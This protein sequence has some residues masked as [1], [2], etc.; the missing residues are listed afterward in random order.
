M[1]IS[2]LSMIFHLKFDPQV[3]GQNCLETVVLGQNWLISRTK[4]TV[5][6]HYYINQKFCQKTSV[7]DYEPVSHE[8]LS[9]AQL[10]IYHHQE[11]TMVHTQ[12]GYHS[13]PPC[14]VLQSDGPRGFR[15]FSPEPL[16]GFISN[17]HHWS[18]VFLN[19]RNDLHRFL[20]IISWNAWWICFKFD[21]RLHFG[22]PNY[23]L[24]FKG[25]CP[26]LPLRAEPLFPI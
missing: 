14:P 18:F 8:F 19:T 21:P 12:Y 17:F 25:I 15:P 20:A 6:R 5:S 4:V 11:P 10:D 26:I 16:D 13:N 9:T 22:H 2:I 23:W 1:H 3:A 7:H 24:A